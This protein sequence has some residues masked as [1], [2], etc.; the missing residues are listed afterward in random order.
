M[1]K[2]SPIKILAFTIFLNSILLFGQQTNYTILVSLDAFRWDYSDRGL[3]PNLDYILKNGVHALSLQ[4]CFPSKTFPSHYSIVT[5]MHPENHGIIANDFTNLFTDQR[6]TLWDSI[7]KNDAKWYKGEGIWETAK[8]QG[9]MTASYFWPGSEANVDY[10]RPDY[11]KKFIYT[12]PYDQRINGAMEWLQ[13]PYEK[14]PHLIMLYFDATDTCGHNYG[15]NSKEVDQAIAMEDSLIGKLFLGLQKLN[16]LDSTNIIIVSDHGMTKLSPERV[17]N[18]DELLSEFKFKISDKGPMMFIYPEEDQKNAVYQKLKDS[19]KNYKVYWKKD[20]P[21]YLHYKNNPLVAEII[22]LADLGYSLFNTQD[23][24][25]YSKKF[26]LGNHGY[27]PTNMDM[28][29][30]FYAIGPDFKKAFSTGTINNID[31]YPLLAKLLCIFPNV[32]IDGKLERI[33]FLLK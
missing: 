14:R 4:P 21:D 33:E 7:A 29:G 25:K 23:I 28:Q 9:V 11:S 6:Y 5:G 8:R 20:F 30:I 15:P 3:T 12:T 13:L 16:L 10:R 26:P 17:I 27:D 24:E 32:N 2:L 1:K 18:I 22:V 19:E 31:I